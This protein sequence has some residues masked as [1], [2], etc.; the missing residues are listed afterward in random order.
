MPPIFNALTNL[1][2]DRD[3]ANP[4]GIVDQE[5]YLIMWR[6]GFEPWM[7]D[8]LARVNAWCERYNSRW[9]L[10]EAQIKGNRRGE[11][12]HTTEGIDRNN[13]QASDVG[14]LYNLLTHL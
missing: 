7:R 10:S 2:S 8:L 13:K 3:C 11:H 12:L 6:S 5:G 9:I 4:I 1:Y 14:V